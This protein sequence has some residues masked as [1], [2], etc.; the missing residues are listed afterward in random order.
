M[1]LYKKPPTKNE[2][3]LSLNTLYNVKGITIHLVFLKIF[4]YKV[5][6]Y[7]CQLLKSRVLIPV[8]IVITLKMEL[9][10]RF[11]VQIFTELCTWCVNKF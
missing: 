2:T 3:T 8:F 5:Q 7:Y 1:G 6:V 10:T 11:W 4:L 9:P